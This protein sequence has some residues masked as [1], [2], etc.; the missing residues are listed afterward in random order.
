MKQKIAYAWEVFK[1][2]NLLAMIML[3]TPITIISGLIWREHIC[4]KRYGRSW[5][6]MCLEL[7]EKERY[8]IGEEFLRKYFGQ[9]IYNHY[10]KEEGA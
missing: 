2:L 6:S 1:E 8:E 3:T 5:N 10:R 7:T 4:R 9:R